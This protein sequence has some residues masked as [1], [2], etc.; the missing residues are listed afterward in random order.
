MTTAPR[1]CPQ[2]PLGDLVELVEPGFASGEK[3]ESGIAQ[4]R[5]NNVTT[6][7]QLD[8]TSIRRVP[9][10]P[11]QLQRYRLRHGDV[12]F[13]STNSPELVGKAAV[14]RGVDEPTVFSNHFLRIRPR[15]DRLDG[16]YLVRW[17]NVL[18][19]R[20]HFETRCA[21]WV[22]QATFRRDDL[23][24]LR[25]PLPLLAE[26]RRIAAI[27]DKADVVR[28]KR[29]QAIQL[30]D[31]LLR[32]AFLDLFGNLVTNERNWRTVSLRELLSST[33]QNGL[34]RPAGSYGRGYPIVRIDSFYDG[35]V[36]RVSDLKR[37]ELTDSEA[38][39]YLL[40]ESDLL[41]NR[42]NSL[43]FLGKAAIVRSLASPTVFESNMMRLQ[44]DRSLVDPDFLVAQLTGQFARRQILGRARNAVNQSS[45]NQNDVSSLQVR[46][47]ALALQNKFVRFKTACRAVAARH[48]EA[49]NRSRD[50]SVSLAQRAFRGELAA[51]GTT[52]SQAG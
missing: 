31:D 14:F 40:Q 35:E 12:L 48:A 37:V 17:L 25:V 46:L 32:S 49:F 18:W 28:R 1:G 33:P 7:G 4:V 45:I 16:G 42:V 6:D 38:A 20:R 5:M 43:R 30:T 52:C 50:L 2:V 24:L 47:P 21:Q 36:V 34:Y 3:V 27:L 39:P 22:N 13:N 51:T 8:W 11:R 9:V 15:P 44:V 19:K 26:Q 41:V 29:Q 23:L 10:T